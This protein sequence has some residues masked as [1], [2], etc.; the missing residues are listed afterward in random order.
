MNLF[1]SL[2]FQI[3]IVELFIHYPLM[4]MHYNKGGRH[5]SSSKN[6]IQQI[7]PIPSLCYIKKCIVS[8][9]ILCRNTDILCS[10]WQFLDMYFSQVVARWVEGA[11]FSACTNRAECN[12]DGL[13]GLSPV[14][15]GWWVVHYGL[16]RGVTSWG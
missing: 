12:V 8:N 1:P 2:T 6:L 13:L 7:Y 3:P 16:S 5:F 11:L 15:R 4:K 9:F 10:V 14:V